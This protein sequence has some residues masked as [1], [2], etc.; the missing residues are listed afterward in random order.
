MNRL[1]FWVHNLLFARFRQPFPISFHFIPCLI[2]FLSIHFTLIAQQT[3]TPGYI[4]KQNHD[5]S[6]GQIKTMAETDQY[7][8]VYFKT[9]MNGEWVSY[10]Y[11]ALLGFGFGNEIFRSIRFLNT[12]TGNTID[13]AFARLLV[14][15]EYNL[16]TYFNNGRRFFLLQ[17]DTNI[18]QLY[19]D[20]ISTSGETDKAGNYQNFLNFISLSCDKLKNKYKRVGYNEKS[21]SD[22]IQETNN[23]LS[24]GMSVS[25]YTK[26]KA[27]VSAII[28]VGG[29]PV[30]T[31]K[32]QLSA[33][34]TVRIT[35]P[36]V[37]EKLS[38]N[39]GLN[40]SV[41]NYMTTYNK[42]LNPL[43]RYYTREEIKS[44]PIT[45]QYNITQKRIQ[46]YF[47]LGVSGAYKD[48]ENLASGWYV[49]PSDKGYGAS[50]VAGLGIEARLV[51]GLYIRA[52]WRFEY[53]I[54]YPAIGI[55]YHF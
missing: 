23:C 2:F 40:Y 14:S 38:L 42:T 48:E 51:A 35:I 25:Y 26:P 19:D 24:G 6:R 41:T 8:S 18:N 13:T 4:I 44:I 30:S 21:L 43:Y 52:D 31:D 11:S 22:F 50:V 45:L 39:F 46:P 16:Y 20:L 53:I 47:Y 29:L 32:S 28:F 7:E 34:L 1:P 49:Q 17:K 10:G 54:Q 55:S 33:N 3:L 15:G 9:A 12:S 37:N 5:T 27:R 36:R